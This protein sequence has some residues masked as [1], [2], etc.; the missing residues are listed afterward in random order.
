MPTQ[1]QLQERF[2][3]SKRANYRES[4]RLEGFDTSGRKIKS[5]KVH[6]KLKELRAQDEESLTQLIKECMSEKD[7]AIEVN[8]ED[9]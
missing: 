4:L 1:K 5:V 3:T 6:N 2:E 7:Q 8:L 9:L